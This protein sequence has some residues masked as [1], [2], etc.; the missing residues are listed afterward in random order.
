MN[1]NE[2]LTT[3]TQTP[4]AN[5][6]EH[7][8]I[9]TGR[10]HVTQVGSDRAFVGMIGLA[11]VCAL[12]GFALALLGD[13]DAVGW[14]GIGQALLIL[15][16][17]ALAILGMF[18][19]MVAWM[20]LETHWVGRRGRKLFAGSTV[21]RMHDSG[22]SFEA[23][24]EIPWCDVLAVD[25]VPDSDCDFT[26][27][28]RGFGRLVVQA[29]ARDGFVEALNAH[30]LCASQRHA[31]AAAS[32]DVLRFSAVVFSWRRFLAWIVFG[33]VLGAV[34]ALYMLAYG[35]E[36]DL[37]WLKVLTG[38]LI[39]PAI[40]TALIWEIPLAGLSLF[41]AKRVRAFVLNDRRLTDVDGALMIDLAQ[42]VASLEER[43]GLAYALCFLRV[44]SH[45]DERLDLLIDE[46]SQSLLLDHLVRRGVISRR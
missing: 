44:A 3:V 4:H 11:M 24:G 12:P 23:L 5:V 15:G 34:F 19:G 9:F 33:Y 28:T 6:S 39:V 27:A 18:G 41:R 25:G 20:V 38:A 29:G 32:G 40:F 2:P 8:P 36:N 31:G 30:R 17:I 46:P 1:A 26:L 21:V 16:G 13:A 37:G 43:K 42:A 7:V 35:I 45:N 22:L 14:R 10:V